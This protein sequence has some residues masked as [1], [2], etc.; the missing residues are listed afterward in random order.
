MWGFDFRPLFWM[1]AI[2]MALGGVT[3]FGAGY[4]YK[5]CGGHPVVRWEKNK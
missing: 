4:A 5:G 3:C 2:V 1:M